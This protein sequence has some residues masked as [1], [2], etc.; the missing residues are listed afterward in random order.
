VLG[1]LG[2]DGLAIKLA[3]EAYREVADVD[4]LLHLAKSLGDDLAGF[5]GD[6]E[7]EIILG[8]AQFLTQ[9]AHELA[10]PRRR[11]RPPDRK[12][13][14]GVGNDDARILLPRRLEVGDALAGDRRGHRKPL[15]KRGLAHAEGGQDGECLCADRSAGVH[16]RV[17]GLA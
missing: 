12:G 8:G 7:A 9:Q 10:T 17:S 16:A 11:H 5:D 4:H 15:P 13:L 14:R 6:Q 2:R 3:R 1:P